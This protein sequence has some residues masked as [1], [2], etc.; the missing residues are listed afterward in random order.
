MRAALAP[1]QQL[2]YA[3]RDLSAS[4]AAGYYSIHL[5]QQVKLVADALGMLD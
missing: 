2:E 4:P 3:G 1:H 5:E